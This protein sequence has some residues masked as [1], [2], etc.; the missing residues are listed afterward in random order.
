MDS[1]TITYE[2]QVFGLRCIE[3]YPDKMCRFCTP[4][5]LG[6]SKC[7]FF[8]DLKLTDDGSVLRHKW[9]LEKA[10]NIKEKACE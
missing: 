10:Q 9:C 2:I 5:P 6:T 8:G 1:K 7:A 3:S 4:M